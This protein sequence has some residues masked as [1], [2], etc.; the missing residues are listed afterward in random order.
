MG[1][2]L[3]EKRRK[4]KPIAAMVDHDLYIL[5]LFTKVFTFIFAHNSNMLLPI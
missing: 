1:R 4:Y 3:K 2:L 5:E